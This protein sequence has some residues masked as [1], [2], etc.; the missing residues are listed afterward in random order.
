MEKSIKEHIEEL[1][2]DIPLT[3]ETEEIKKQT[4]RKALDCYHDAVVEGKKPETACK[5]A[6]DQIG[7]VKLLVEHQNSISQRR[8]DSV[9]TKA[10]VRKSKHKQGL[11][12]GAAVF[13]YINCLTPSFWM[14]SLLAPVL[15]FLLAAAATVLIVYNKNTKLPQYTGVDLSQEEKTAI[16]RK[17]AII[18]ALGIIFC[19]FAAISAFLQSKLLFSDSLLNTVLFLTV[20]VGVGLLVYNKCGKIYYTDKTALINQSY[21]K[22]EAEKTPKSRRLRSCRCVLWL[23]A[24]A[25]YLCLN[26]TTAALFATWLVFAA[27]FAVD[28]VLKNI[29]AEKDKTKT[30]I[31]AVLSVIIVLVLAAGIMIGTSN[32]NLDII[33][34]GSGNVSY[35]NADMYSVGNVSLEQDITDFEINWTDGTVDIAAYDGDTL[36]ITEDGDFSDQAK[37]RYYQSGGKLIVQYCKSNIGISSDIPHNKKLQIKIPSKSAAKINEIKISTTSAQVQ[38]SGIKAKTVTVD[39]ISGS[40]SCADT[41]AETLKFSSVAAGCTFEGVC[42]NLIFDT[43]SG[44]LT[45]VCGKQPASLKASSLSGNVSLNLPADSQGFTAV[46]SSLSTDFETDFFVTESKKGYSFGDGSALY[47]VDTINGKFSIMQ[48]K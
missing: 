4:M 45:A 21:E 26:M 19:V 46:L 14:D 40:L 7:D 1:F 12:M 43:T 28:R 37:L 44:N 6:I 2:A 38:T 35:E 13:L 9:F 5:K 23:A 41:T 36:E 18:K 29:I 15:I 10:D 25:L 39:N 33:N 3:E 16:N 32:K 30:I 8:A 27:A 42:E 22:W 34:L 24:V 11:L 20:G 48:S 31:F 47:N 17:S